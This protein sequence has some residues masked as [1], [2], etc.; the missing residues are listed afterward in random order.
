M[1]HDD[2]KHALSKTHAPFV[3]VCV[4][5]TYSDDPLLRGPSMC[6]GLWGKLLLDRET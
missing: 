4:P 2:E 3:A 6:R 1:V 5:N